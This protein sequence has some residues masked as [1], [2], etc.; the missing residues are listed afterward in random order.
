MISKNLPPTLRYSA[1]EN[2]KTSSRA[3]FLPATWGRRISGGTLA[4]FARGLA[5]MI[6]ARLPV[7]EALRAAAVQA[8]NAPLRDALEQTRKDVERGQ[9]LSH[10]LA[11]HERTFGPLFARMVEI[12]EAA[13]VLDD[14]L[15]RLPTFLEKSSA[16]KQKVRMA[17]MYPAVILVVAMGAVV[18]MLTVIVPTFAGMFADFGAELPAPTRVVVAVSTLVTGQLGWLAAAGVLIAITSGYCRQLPAVRDRLDRI[19][20]RLPFAGAL[21]TKSEAARL[22]RTLGTL[23]KSGVALTDALMVTER[24]SENAVVRNLVSE[25]RQSTARGQPLSRPLVG[26]RVFPPMVVHMLQ[27]GEE[28]AT[29][30]ETL[31]H[32]ASHYEA[33]LDRLLDGLS[34][35]IEPVLIVLIGAVVGA[36]LVALYLPIFEL[37]GLSGVE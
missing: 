2:R 8:T 35:V 21:V 10:A 11:R 30:P 4:E 14:V 34:S 29:L 7:V 37:V 33:E 16:L 22:C 20:L 19:R 24:A 12:G 28:T 3:L 6:S 26:S 32:I 25:M 17:L 31:L 5:V 36:I 13:G 1:T 15:L 23:M 18:F 9:S 27:V